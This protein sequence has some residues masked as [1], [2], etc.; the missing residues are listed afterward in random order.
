M[1]L[2][3]E[4]ELGVFVECKHIM[5]KPKKAPAKVLFTWLFLF[6]LLLNW[7]YVRTSIYSSFP[8]ISSLLSVYHVLLTCSCPQTVG[9]P[10]CAF[11]H[12]FPHQEPSIGFICL[13]SCNF[14]M[15]EGCGYRSYG[16]VVRKSMT[17]PPK[18]PLVSLDHPAHL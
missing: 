14:L 17:T 1:W 18:N 13:V 11:I 9:K 3:R 6:K 2:Y 15:Q 8:F 5:T 16:C 12:P 4:R 10:L 7:G